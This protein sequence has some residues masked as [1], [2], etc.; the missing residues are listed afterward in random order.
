MTTRSPSQ[1]RQSSSTAELTASRRLHPEDLKIGDDVAI[2]ETHHE[3]A[4]CCWLG[5]DSFQYPPDELIRLTF[6]A[7]GDHHPQKIKSICLPFVLCQQ[8]DG[9]H[10][11]HDLRQVQLTRLDAGFASDVTTA[12]K[13]DKGDSKKRKKKKK[14]KKKGKKKSDKNKSGEKK[15]RR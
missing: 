8:S 11:V 5:L 1:K 6:K 7:F 15:K 14:N 2:S 3:L 12:L 10:I 4:T 13:S 9:K